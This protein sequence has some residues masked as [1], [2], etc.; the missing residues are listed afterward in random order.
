MTEVLPDDSMMVFNDDQ[1]H[2][3]V[4]NG[5]CNFRNAAG[6]PERMV[7]REVELETLTG[8]PIVA[9]DVALYWRIY[10]TLGI[11]PLGEHGR[12]LSSLC[13]V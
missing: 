10:K 3:I 2:A 12:L 1:S 13:A 7:S 11:A 5:M 6:L 8:K 4:V 9:S